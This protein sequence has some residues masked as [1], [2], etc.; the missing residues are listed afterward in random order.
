MLSASHASDQFRVVCAA[1]RDLARYVNLLEELAD[2]LHSRGI[3]QWPRGRARA[4]RDYYAA[5]IDAHEVFLALMG[6]A[7]AGAVRLLDRDPIVWPDAGPDDALYV[8]N[9]AVRRAF[10]GQGVG[11]R[12]LA[13]AE[14]QAAR[15]GR[16]Y[17]R[18]DCFPDNSFLRRYY[19]DAGF[20]ERGEVDAVYPVIGTMHLRRYEKRIEP[21]W[22]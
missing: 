9:L 1:E 10:A 16:A 17:M 18:L 3:D 19:E 14:Q 21:A 11:R 5:S 20:V 22:R 7:L 13:W 8:Y 6:E 15:R 12:L 4:G 2:W